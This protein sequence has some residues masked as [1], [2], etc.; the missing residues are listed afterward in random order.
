MQINRHITSLFL[1]GALLIPVFL[2]GCAGGSIRVGY[3]TYDPY[4]NDYHRWDNDE[5][6]FYNRWTVETHRPARVGYR[7]LGG[8]EQREYWNWR[9]DHK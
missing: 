2:T 8:D 1:A 3:R 7:R 9:H 4:F 6:G 5:I